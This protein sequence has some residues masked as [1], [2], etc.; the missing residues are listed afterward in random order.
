MRRWLPSLLALATALCLVTPA[1]ADTSYVVQPGDTL[2]RIAAR[3]GVTVQAIADA[4]RL[5]NPNAIV[6]GQTLTIPD[7]QPAPVAGATT[8]STY[9]VQPGDSLSRL[10]ARF[11][12]TVDALVAANGLT[13]TTLQIGQVLTVPGATPAQAQP[14]IYGRIRGDAA[15]TRRIQAALDWL[16]AADPEAFARVD[17]YINVIRPSPYRDRAQAVPL[18]GGGCLVRALA[19][20]GQ[21]VQMV[22]ALLYHEA[23][24]CL[25]FA[26]VGLLSSREAEVQAY[27]EQIA[28]MEKHGYPEEVLDYYRR[29]LEYY[30]SQPD[31]GQYI[32]PP[33]F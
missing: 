8:S 12:V 19:R 18:Q 25:Q 17:T 10:A 24:H 29:I 1:F 32:P 28:F 26:T 7:G 16:Q 21:G 9:I 2:T 4:N 6:V 22:A 31:N 23:T 33:D 15:F 20:P 3:F 14:G 27:S 13:T 5:A 30:A 11:N